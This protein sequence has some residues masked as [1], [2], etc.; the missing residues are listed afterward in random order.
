MS[1]RAIPSRI[2]FALAMVL[3]FGSEGN[4][5]VSNE[6]YEIAE[7][8]SPEARREFAD[9]ISS[10]AQDI[11][12]ERI[13]FAVIGKIILIR[14]EDERFCHEES[15]ITIVSTK[16]GRPACQYT[17]ALVPPRYMWDSAGSTKWGIFIRFPRKLGEAS[18]IVANDRFLASYQGI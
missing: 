16:C 6:Q 10:F 4:A 5:Y 15:C 17:T 9:I 18:V 2:F 11:P 12:D 1:A 8:I 13:K 7:T 3:F 14:L